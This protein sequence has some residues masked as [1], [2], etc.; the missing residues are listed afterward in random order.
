M[1]N[2]VNCVCNCK[3]FRK[4]ATMKSFL[5]HSFLFVSICLGSFIIHLCR[6]LLRVMYLSRPF[7]AFFWIW[8]TLL[9]H[10]PKLFVWWRCSVVAFMGIDLHLLVAS[11]TIS[12]HGQHFAP[13][14]MQIRLRFTLSSVIYRTFQMEKPCWPAPFWWP[15]LFMSAILSFFLDLCHLLVC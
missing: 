13:V 1:R 15:W 8:V 10:A 4:S 6:H 9:P 11:F 12:E 7:L 3:V 2:F 14:L 5:N